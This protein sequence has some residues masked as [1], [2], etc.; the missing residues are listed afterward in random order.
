[1][2]G[3]AGTI[4]G[5]R[6]RTYALVKA[7]IGALGPVASAIDVGAGDGWYARSLMDDGVVARCT[8]VDVTRRAGTVLEPLLYDGRRLPFDDRSTD[9]VYA[10]DVVHHADV[11]ADLL[12]EMARVARRWIVLKDHTYVTASGRMALALLDELG[13]RRFGIP[14]PGRY[15]RAWE[16]LP[17]LRD[18]GFEPRGIVHPASCQAGL[19]GALTNRWQFV[20]AFER[21]HAD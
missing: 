21:A 13:N 5:Y 8:P 7:A 12:K 11:P 14:S 18:A 9:L 15:Q 1:M 3:G 4:T 2:W 6:G 19:L 17:I 20:A 16:W 10:V